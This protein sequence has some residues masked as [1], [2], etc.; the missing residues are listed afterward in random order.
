V[1]EQWAVDVD[2]DIDTCCVRMYRP[3]WNAKDSF[4]L[5]T[6]RFLSSLLFT[7]ILGYYALEDGG[8]RVMPTERHL[9]KLK[10]ILSAHLVQVLSNACDP[11]DICNG[12]ELAPRAEAMYVKRRIP[13]S[14]L[15]RFN[16]NFQ[17][18]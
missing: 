2:E 16:F 8:V 15:L 13:L 1:V 12:V 3:E 5:Q 4:R 10:I 9:G 6:K 14:F 18:H 11:S 17:T 7:C